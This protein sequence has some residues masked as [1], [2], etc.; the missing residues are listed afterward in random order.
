MHEFLLLTLVADHLAVFFASGVMTSTAGESVFLSF[1]LAQRKHLLR[2]GGQ[3]W[4]MFRTARGTSDKIP[5]LQM[6][7]FTT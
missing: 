3:C 4:V 6:I 5:Q 1:N 2:P 7:C